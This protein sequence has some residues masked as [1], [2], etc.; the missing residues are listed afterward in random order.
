MEYERKRRI[1]GEISVFD[2]VTLSEMGKTVGEDQFSLSMSSLRCP[3]DTQV[4]ILSRKMKIRFWGLGKSLELEMQ[5][6]E[7]L[8]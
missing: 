5:M 2:L 3:L 7:L 8:A 1:K 6:W 4:E